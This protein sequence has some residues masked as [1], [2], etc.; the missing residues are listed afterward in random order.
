MTTR[1]LV[2]GGTSGIGYGMACRIAASSPTSS[3]IISGRTKPDHI[4][5]GNMEFQPIEATSM[6]EIKNFTDK[7]K[8]QLSGTSQ[9]QQV[10][11]A[12]TNKLDFLIMTQGIMT[13]AGR[14]ETPEGIDRK[15]ALHYYGKQLLIRELLPALKEDAKVV[16][17]YDS[18]FGN[19]DKVHWEDLD[20]KTQFSLGTASNHCM[21][22]NDAMINYFASQQAQGS[23]K[24][25][26]ANAKRHF[27]HAWPGGVNT[28]LM[29]EM[30][31][32]LGSIAKILAPLAT[33][34]PATCAEY[35]LNGVE[36]VSTPAGDNEERPRWSYIDNKG[37]VVESKPIL[38]E[39]QI[40]KIAEHTWELV[41]VALK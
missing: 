26:G 7:L 15:M 21:V 5:H 38:T 31:W 36:K 33:V 14:T 18:K 19:P 17:V 29:R 25:Q 24:Q 40:G 37:R 4:P 32:Y 35:L 10:H 1:A 22:M 2:V 11:A 12:E 41:G 27:I 39:E 9:G 30:P 20:L 23:A 34:S 8:Q 13:I 3:V 28:S 16:I 6:R